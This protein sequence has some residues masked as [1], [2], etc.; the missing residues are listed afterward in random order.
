MPAGAG[1]RCPWLL[2]FNCPHCE[3]VPPYTVGQHLSWFI[4]SFCA[5]QKSGST[6]SLKAT[7]GSTN[8]TLLSLFCHLQGLTWAVSV[9]HTRGARPGQSSL[10]VPEFPL[11]SS[12]SLE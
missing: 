5:S 8:P 4:L 10:Q 7:V 2:V 1:L 3:N 12:H 11:L 9:S 6:I